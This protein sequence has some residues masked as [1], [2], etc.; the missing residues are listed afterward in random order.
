MI[1]R[2]LERSSGNFLENQNRQRLVVPVGHKYFHDILT[3]YQLHRHAFRSGKTQTVVD[4]EPKPE[5]E[6]MVISSEV[7]DLSMVLESGA[8]TELI[9]RP[10]RGLTKTTLPR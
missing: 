4:G 1:R 9:Y 3:K 7:R 8:L 5:E 2:F 6:V 10:Q